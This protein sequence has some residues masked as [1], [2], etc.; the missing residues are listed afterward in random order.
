MSSSRNPSNR[1][2]AAAWLL[3]LATA[4]VTLKAAAADPGVWC[5]YADAVGMAQA[6]CWLESPRS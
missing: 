1:R 4:L 5:D 6:G 3:A 2:R